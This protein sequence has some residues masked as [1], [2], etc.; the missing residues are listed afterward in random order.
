VEWLNIFHNVALSNQSKY[1]EFN[2]LL[3]KTIAT[4]MKSLQLSGTA[5]NAANAAASYFVS[6]TIMVKPN[7][8]SFPSVQE[9]LSSLPALIPTYRSDIKR[10][11]T[12]ASANMFLLTPSGVVSVEV[13][14]DFFEFFFFKSEIFSRIFL[15]LI[16]LL[17]NK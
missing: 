11:I 16:Q 12:T 7:L 8:L 10:Q 14:I 17:Y 5:P 4:I 15:F 13:E 9:Y 1:M 3:S 2:N 6:L